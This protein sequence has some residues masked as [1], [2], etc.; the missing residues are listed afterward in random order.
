MIDFQD[1]KIR[2]NVDLLLKAGVAALL[3]VALLSTFTVS[4]YYIFNR[5]GQFNAAFIISQWVKKSGL[6]LLPLAIYYKR[7]C[8]ADIAK[9]LLPPFV[10]ISCFTYGSFFDITMITEN[11]TP[12]QIIFARINEFIPKEL[13]IFL[14]FFGNALI[15]L[16]CA[17]LFIRDGA[18]VKAA[19][20]KYFPA[21]FLSV[22]PLNIFENFFDVNDIAADSFLR[23]RNFTVWHFGAIIF[24]AAFTI[25]AYCLL[26]D[27]SA[28]KKQN[29]LAAIAVV[30]LIQYHSKDSMLAGDGYNVYKTVFSAIPLFICNLGVYVA[31]IAVFTKRRTLYSLSFFVHAAGA[32]TVFIY[33]GKDEMSNYGIFCSYTILYFVLTHCLLFAL[34]VLPSA[35]GQYKFRPKDAIVPL[36]YYFI[37]IVVAAFT[38]G[39][40]TSASMNFSYGGY[41]LAEDEWLIPNFAFTQINPIPVNL[42]LIP[43]RIW[44]YDFNALYLII[45]YTAYVAIF[46]TFNGAYYLLLFARGRLARKTAAQPVS[47]IAASDEDEK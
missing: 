22:T 8:C 31:S 33:F 37:V 20:F 39:I 26:K 18:G 10:L 29:C 41:T 2:K 21:A 40:I 38:S 36:V 6:L 32:V 27:K 12:A 46:Y 44:R 34:C 13:N 16:I 23:F 4:D 19:S 7:K 24:V 11:S 25:C 3:I 47:E 1:E 43:L 9:Y 42:P 5:F 17:A 35:L 28:A 14:F 45:L 15:L 30:L